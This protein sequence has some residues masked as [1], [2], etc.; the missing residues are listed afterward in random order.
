MRV[1]SCHLILASPYFKQML[2]GGW[3]EDCTLSAE[4]CLTIYEE[5]WDPDALLILMNVIHG[6]TRKVAR[7]VSLEMLAKLAVLVDYY[8]CLEVVEVFSEIWIDQLE[9][10]LPTTY[11]RDLILW[12]CISWVFRHPLRFNVATGIALMQSKKPIQTLGLP[13]PETI[14]GRY[15]LGLHN[16]M[17]LTTAQRRSTNKGRNPLIR[18]LRPCTI[19]LST[20]AKAEIHARSN[21]VQCFLVLLL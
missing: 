6:H 7:S 4:G 1:S 19:F 11:S 18:L 8:E 2:R 12:I 10:G 16:T 20:S 21:A 3:K 15:L 17:S 9:K 5:D 13:I 14:V